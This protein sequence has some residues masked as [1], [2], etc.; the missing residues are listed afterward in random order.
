MNPIV[1]RERRRYRRYIVSGQVRI[2]TNSAETVGE[3]VNFGQGGLQVRSQSV[4]PVGTQA[5]FC[6]TAF[7]YPNPF[8]IAGEIVGGKNDLMAVKFLGSANGVNEL[9][10]WLDQENFPWTGTFD[11]NPPEAEKLVVQA[12]PAPPETGCGAELEPE[13]QF[14]FQQA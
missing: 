11:S 10:H 7:C 3:L 12:S 5:V 2:R 1:W 4:L 6:V 9:L 14:V 13:M 8:D